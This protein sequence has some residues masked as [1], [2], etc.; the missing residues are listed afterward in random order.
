MQD[1]PEL[2]LLKPDADND[3]TWQNGMILRWGYS[4]QGLGQN[5]PSIVP[6]LSLEIRGTRGDPRERPCRGYPY[7]SY[8]QT[9]P[10]FQKMCWVR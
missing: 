5:C 4:V 7:V 8:N 6:Q 1:H 3:G 2:G 9:H 10:K